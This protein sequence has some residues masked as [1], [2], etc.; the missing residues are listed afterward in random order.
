MATAVSTGSLAAG[1]TTVFTG[2][3]YLNS[4]TLLT[5]GVN[6]ASIQIFD[7]TAGS[8]TLIAQAQLAAAGLPTTVVYHTPLRCDVGMTVV[9]AGTGATA[10]VGWGAAS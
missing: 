3:T 10:L 5:D 2:K 9:V 6:T 7:N 4:F 1:T 8:G